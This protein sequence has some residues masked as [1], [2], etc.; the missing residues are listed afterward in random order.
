MPDKNSII[1]DDR[2][3]QQVT[4][5][6]AGN[7]AIANADEPRRTEVTSEH[8][9]INKEESNE[10]PNDIAFIAPDLPRLD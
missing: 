7:T 8:V 3:E 9:K 1:A 2:G 4:P 5:I 10:N 6:N